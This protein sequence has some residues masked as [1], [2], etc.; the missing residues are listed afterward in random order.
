MPEV[1]LGTL[2]PIL[3]PT[4]LPLISDT[5]LRFH[6]NHRVLLTR[7]TVLIIPTTHMYPEIF[8]RNRAAELIKRQSRQRDAETQELNPR[9]G[10]VEEEHGREY[11]QDVFEHAG[12]GE[13]QR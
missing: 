11:Y 5:Q 2:D 13:D 3:N 10:V 8:K 7:S 12:E 1:I 6:R 4:I 9:H